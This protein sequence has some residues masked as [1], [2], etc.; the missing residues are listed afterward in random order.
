MD[1]DQYQLATRMTAI[2]PKSDAV[3]YTLLGL[4]NEAG[5]IQGKYKKYLRDNV[6]WNDVKE[7][8]LDELGD[9]LWYA[10]RLADELHFDLSEVMERN[11]AKLQ[12]RQQRG[13]IG[14]SGDKR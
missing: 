11:L 9:V 3:I 14:G 10:A 1:A 13:V 5:E 2:Y 6:E 7:M 12:S 8:M 4:G